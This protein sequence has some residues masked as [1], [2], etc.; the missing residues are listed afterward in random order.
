M[1]KFRDIIENMNDETFETNKQSVINNLL[2]KTKTIKEQNNRYWRE[3]RLFRYQF[4]REQ[5]LSKQI[6]LLNKKDILKF[7]DQYIY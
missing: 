1:T 6:K 2:E 3:I 5:Q 7:H 4:Q